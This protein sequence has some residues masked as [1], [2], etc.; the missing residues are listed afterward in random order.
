M[1]LTQ[2]QLME[3]KRT[4]AEAMG[5]AN[6]RPARDSMNPEL[7]LPDWHFELIGDPPRGAEGVK[8]RLYG[9]LV[10][11]YPNNPAQIAP[12][13]EHFRQRWVA[14][15]GSECYRWSIESGRLE[16]QEY[17]VVIRNWQGNAV[18]RGDASTLERA[19]CYAIQDSLTDCDDPTPTPQEE[20]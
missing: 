1:A 5:W 14:A 17:R 12:M 11:D 3:L 16:G 19:I 7:H 13:L 10:P 8:V 20:Q 15:S 18:A 4:V 2:Q 6:I 9:S